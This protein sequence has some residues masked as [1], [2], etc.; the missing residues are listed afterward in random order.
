MDRARHQATTTELRRHRA[1]TAQASYVTTCTTNDG[2][3]DR[4]ANGTCTER[5]HGTSTDGTGTE[6][7]TRRDGNHRERHEHRRKQRRT[8]QKAPNR[9]RKPEG[10]ESCA[11]NRR[12]EVRG[13]PGDQCGKKYADPRKMDGKIEPWSGGAKNV[14]CGG[15]EAM[16]SCDGGGDALGSRAVQMDGRDPWSGVGGGRRRVV[17]VRW[18][19]GAIVV[20]GG[21]NVY[22]GCEGGGRGG[23]TVQDGGGGGSG[24][25]GGIRRGRRCDDGWRGRGGAMMGAADEWKGAHSDGRRW[26][27]IR[28]AAVVGRCECTV[29][30]AW[31]KRVGGPRRSGQTM[32]LIGGSPGDS[33]STTSAG[34]RR[35]QGTAA[36]PGTCCADARCVDPAGAMC[37][38]GGLAGERVC[39][40]ST[41]ETRMSCT[42]GASRNIDCADGHVGSYRDG[43]CAWEKTAA[44]QEQRRTAGERPTPRHHRDE[45]G[46]KRHGRAAASAARAGKRRQTGRK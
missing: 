37:A 11:Q 9:Q 17:D 1:T 42:L 44:C 14:L 24:G 8:V 20:G 10:P 7:E 40:W 32:S 21:C 18:I 3:C 45:Q 4:D 26:I 22:V 35:D 12:P 19:G 29:H 6:T 39:V 30:R 23:A 33:S 34:P 2:H 41:T 25:R 5:Q 38:R 31:W 36:N 43:A 46:R 28:A 13:G 27:I 16:D 15:P